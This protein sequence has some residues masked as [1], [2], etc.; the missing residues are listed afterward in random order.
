VSAERFTASLAFDQRLDLT[1]GIEGLAFAGR[2]G[3]TPDMGRRDNVF[4]ACE[5][6]R[7]HLIGRPAD[8]LGGAGDSALGERV[9]DA[10][11]VRVFG[12]DAVGELVQVGLADVCVAG[13]FEEEH[14]FGR[15][16]RHVVGEDRRAVG[17][18]QPGGVE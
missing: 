5:F 10:A 14:G 18:L 15:P 2:R 9:R 1:D 6:R 13:R 4:Q 12:G 11:V 17:R 3:Q 16:R 8:I 7:R